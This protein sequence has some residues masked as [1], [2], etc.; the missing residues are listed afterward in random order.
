MKRNI[1]NIQD[2]VFDSLQTD[3]ETQGDI[4]CVVRMDNQQSNEFASQLQPSG[5]N[6]FWVL[7]VITIGRGF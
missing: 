2:Q 1:L 7:F 3:K 5:E 4:Y 6:P